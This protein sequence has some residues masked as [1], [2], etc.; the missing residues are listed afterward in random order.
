MSKYGVKINRALNYAQEKLPEYVELDEAAAIAAFSPYHFHRVFIL[1]V[2]ETFANFMRKRRLE[3]AAHELLNTH[4]RIIDIS[5][6]VGYD[7]QESFAR[8][9]KNQFGTT[10]NKFRKQTYSPNEALLSL[11]SSDQNLG[12]FMKPEIIERS[13]FDIIGIQQDY[14][15][16]NFADA[17]A[18]WHNFCVRMEDF[19]STEKTCRYGVSILPTSARLKNNCMGTFRYLTAK[20]AI[21]GE[22]VPEGMIR[23]TVP[24]QKY[25]KYTF[26]GPVSGFQAFI[27]NVWTQYL[28]DSGLEVIESPELEVYD[29]RFSEGSHESEMD[30][31][32]PIK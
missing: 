13:A 19:A 21:E 20:E 22:T 5:L 2:G 15:N 31:L 7:S 3:W 10:P 30:Y 1:V 28:P 9:F 29:E 24:S 16:P 18:Q 11:D 8:A 6:D 17:L 12:E 4:R 14:E 23:Y 26:T 32:I 25:A 27:M